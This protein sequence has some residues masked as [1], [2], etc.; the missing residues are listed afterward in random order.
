MRNYSRAWVYENHVEIFIVYET[1][2]NNTFTL[3]TFQEWFDG[4][5]NGKKL[6]NMVKLLSTESGEW[7]HINVLYIIVTIH[8]NI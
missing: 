2:N 8:S 1:T 6:T 7:I 4:A 3:W 5:I